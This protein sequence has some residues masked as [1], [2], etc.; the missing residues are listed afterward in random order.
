MF[1]THPPF[2]F[3]KG[4]KLD[5]SNGTQ[6]GNYLSNL[7]S[8]SLCFTYRLSREDSNDSSSKSDE[9]EE[10]GENGEVS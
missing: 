2:S 9:S 4:N 7:E 8:L 1:Y 3:L 5:F 10:T 6:I